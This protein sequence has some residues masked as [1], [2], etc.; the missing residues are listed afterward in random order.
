MEGQ[1]Q[2]YVWASGVGLA[3]LMCRRPCD[4]SHLPSAAVAWGTECDPGQWSL[5]RSNDMLLQGTW[6]RRK[7]CC[8]AG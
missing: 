7:L 3:P 8:S 2:D 6:E 1:Q 4:P 5:H